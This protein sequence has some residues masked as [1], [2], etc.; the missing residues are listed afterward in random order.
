MPTKCN[1]AVFGISKSL[2]NFYLLHSKKN[3]E[4][5]QQLEHQKEEMELLKVT[6]Y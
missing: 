5:Q 3:E 1:I 2:F 4:L 6:T